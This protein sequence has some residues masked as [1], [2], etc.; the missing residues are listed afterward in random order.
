MAIETQGWWFWSLIVFYPVLT[1]EVLKMI[2]SRRKFIFDS[3]Y[4]SADER[5]NKVGHRLLLSK[6]LNRL[7]PSAHGAHGSWLSELLLFS[8]KYWGQFFDRFDWTVVH[9]GNNGLFLT[10]DMLFGRDLYGAVRHSLSH[11]FGVSVRL[12]VLIPRESGK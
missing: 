9:Y 10:D 7:F 8:K 1:R 4:P 11:V 12:Y 2:F 3:S 6:A 5:P